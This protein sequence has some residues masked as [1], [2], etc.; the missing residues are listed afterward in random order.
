MKKDDSKFDNNDLNDPALG[1]DD[2]ID[3]GLRSFIDESNKVNKK[4]KTVYSTESSNISK[5]SDPPAGT[6]PVMF[7]TIL[8]LMI[9]MIGWWIFSPSEESHKS[10][11][12]YRSYWSEDCG[13]FVPMARNL[14]NRGCPEFYCKQ[15]SDGSSEYLVKC[16]GSQDIIRYYIV[17]PNINRVMGPYYDAGDLE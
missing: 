17:W 10:G 12:K 15:R 6:I 9:G 16:I 14:V 1:L 4:Y 2:Q 3:N 5:D 13:E 8:I 11:S 7:F